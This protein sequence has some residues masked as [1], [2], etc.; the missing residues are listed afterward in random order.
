MKGEVQR[1]G[2]GTCR[3]CEGPRGMDG[4][5]KAV[6]GGSVGSGTALDA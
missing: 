1:P 2:G 4:P 5:G 6:A 3:E